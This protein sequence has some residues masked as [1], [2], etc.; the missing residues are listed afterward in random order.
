MRVLSGI[1]PGHTTTSSL[2]PVRATSLPRF[3]AS[4]NGNASRRSRAIR[5][6]RQWSLRQ[7]PIVK[8]GKK[9]KRDIPKSSS[10]YSDSCFVR[11]ILAMGMENGQIQ[12]WRA[13]AGDLSRWELWL[14]IDKR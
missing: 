14:D 13:E 8:T 7:D 6:L 4:Q 12:L 3:G 1:A 5:R 2:L 10:F 9:K 11:Y